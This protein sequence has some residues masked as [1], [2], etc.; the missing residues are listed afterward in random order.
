MNTILDTY[1][2]TRLDTNRTQNTLF[3]QKQ[4]WYKEMEKARQMIAD[5]HLGNAHSL[6]TGI[7]Q[8]KDDKT[9]NTYREDDS[10]NT[11]AAPNPDNAETGIFLSGVNVFQ[12][13]INN[14]N[15][16]ATQVNLVHTGLVNGSS[17]GHLPLNNNSPV[18]VTRATLP[19]VEAHFRNELQI[20]LSF[21]NR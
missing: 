5:G 2:F 1:V 10:R 17:A 15:R 8:N 12:P 6:V 11:V 14:V 4:T 7:D 3:S 20:L 18:N 9:E 21:L 13:D 19:D 16:V